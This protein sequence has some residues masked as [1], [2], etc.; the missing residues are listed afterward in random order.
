M[1]LEFRIRQPKTF[2]K[3]I[4]KRTQC[5]HLSLDGPEAENSTNKYFLKLDMAKAYI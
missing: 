3:M 1:H 5:K 4:I 2:K